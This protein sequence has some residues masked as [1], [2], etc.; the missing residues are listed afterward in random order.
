M[1]CILDFEPLKIII[2][3]IT[4]I[5]SYSLLYQIYYSKKLNTKNRVPVENFLYRRVLWDF[6]QSFDIITLG[7][8]PVY[9]SD[10]SSF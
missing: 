8:N 3:N 9:N 4:C 2:L 7:Y 6:K 10:N 1:L 5:Q